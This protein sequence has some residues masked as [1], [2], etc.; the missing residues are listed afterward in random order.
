MMAAEEVA[1]GTSTSP[2]LERSVKPLAP[3]AGFPPP[4]HN[5]RHRQELHYPVVVLSARTPA[6]RLPEFSLRGQPYPQE[7]RDLCRAT[8]VTLWPLQGWHGTLLSPQAH[9]ALRAGSSE[10]R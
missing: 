5:S 4:F 3:Q 7:G 6:P 8:T 1:K 9:S 10:K 2:F